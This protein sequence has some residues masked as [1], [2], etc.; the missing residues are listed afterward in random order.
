VVGSDERPAAFYRRLDVAHD[1]APALVRSVRIEE[2]HEVVE[3]H[4]VPDLSSV[5]GA[6]LGFVGLV[7][8]WREFVGATLGSWWRWSRR[9]CCWPLGRAGVRSPVGLLQPCGRRRRRSEWT[10]DS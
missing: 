2:Q 6:S 8:L 5:R 1:L 10:V 3:P 9:W 4:G 7:W